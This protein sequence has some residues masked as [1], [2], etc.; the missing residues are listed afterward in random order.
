MGSEIMQWY[1][2][3]GSLLL[4]VI[5]IF[6]YQNPQAVVLRF[7][8]WEMP[9]MSL[10]LLIFFSTAMGAMM[11]LLFSL[12]KQIKLGIQIRDLQNKVKHL[13]RELQG[14]KGTQGVN[15]QPEPRASKFAG[16]IKRIIKRNDTN[17]T[18]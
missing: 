9:S 3:L 5:A 15:G 10:V 14:G 16:N 13:E 7:L 8:T 4:L 1:I 18:E 11:T 6:A 12:A 2:A 17:T